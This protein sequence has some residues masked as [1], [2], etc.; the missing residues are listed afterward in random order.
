MMPSYTC[1]TYRTNL[2]HLLVCTSRPSAVSDFLQYEMF[3]LSVYEQTY[4]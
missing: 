2:H 3:G 1:M 4:H